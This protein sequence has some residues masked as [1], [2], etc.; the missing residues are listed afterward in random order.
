MEKGDLPSKI[1]KDNEE[2]SLIEAEVR[3]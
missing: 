3:D 1:M 2:K